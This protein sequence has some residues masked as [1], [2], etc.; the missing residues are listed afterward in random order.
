MALFTGLLILSGI[1]WAVDPEGMA[2]TRD[3]QEQERAEREAAEAEEEAEAE[4]AAE[5]SEAEEA[6]AEEEDSQEIEEPDEEPETDPEPEP[7]PATFEEKLSEIEELD[8]L[9]DGSVYFD[10]TTN[11]IY[12][13][14][15]RE[16]GLTTGTMC[17]RARD[18]SI[19]V[20]E[21][22]RD[23]IDEDYGELWISFS[24]YGEQDATGDAP[25]LGMATLVYS[26]ETVA[27]ID[28]DAISLINVW[29]T[30]DE[31]S[32]AAQCQ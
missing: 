2:E 29:E 8:S 28:S 15:V 32:I 19:E 6:R 31:G 25:I 30:R 21:Y 7:E 17:N 26:A 3:R 22:T 18:A 1:L 20:L 4:R 23:N 10:E 13:D 11:N 24:A 5:E 27:A 14:D 9:D 16:P 12:V